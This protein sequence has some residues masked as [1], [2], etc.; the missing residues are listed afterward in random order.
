LEDPQG[1]LANNC[2]DLY[3]FALR[4][5]EHV[6]LIYASTASLYSSSDHVVALSAESSLLMI[7]EQN[8][9]DISKF[10]FDYF[11]KN[12]LKNFYG[13]RMGTLA[14]HSPNL[15][16]ELVFNAMSLAA[17]N[18]GVIQLKNSRSMRTILF[19][20][21]LW[22]LVKN[23]LKHDHEPG[24]YNAGSYTGSMADLAMGISKVWGARIE[25]KGESTTYSF[26]L[27]VTRMRVVCG[28]ELL[29]CSLEEASRQFIEDHQAHNHH[30]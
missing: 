21:D 3:Q 28:H 9:Y 19:L 6:K 15:R 10:A 11:A 5:P 23:L 18:K 14:G 8:A 1:A 4:L 12:H 30:A 25:H 29:P 17:K 24:F 13:L 7:P 20:N 26:A 16:P 27:D 2:L 22:V